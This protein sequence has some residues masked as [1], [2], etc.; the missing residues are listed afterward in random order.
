MDEVTITRAQLKALHEKQEDI[1][2]TQ[3]NGDARMVLYE[4]TRYRGNR[5]EAKWMMPNGKDRKLDA[6]QPDAA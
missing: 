5:K 3:A 1:T 4:R 2:I 6:D